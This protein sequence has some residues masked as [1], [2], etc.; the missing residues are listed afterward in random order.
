[1]QNLLESLS[2]E[3]EGPAETFSVDFV[4]LTSKLLQMTG[5]FE[6]INQMKGMSGAL[7]K[8]Y[9]LYGRKDN[10][11]YIHLETELEAGD[12][13]EQ[14]LNGGVAPELYNPRMD[15]A[16]RKA[17]SDKASE[18]LQKLTATLGNSKNKKFLP[19]LIKSTILRTLELNV[20]AA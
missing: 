2:Q 14:L 19:V 16:T 12:L 10:V 11:P 8:I 9:K 1:M 18:Q 6:S 17:Y 20:P 4:C 7:E 3:L 13:T 5:L 15:A